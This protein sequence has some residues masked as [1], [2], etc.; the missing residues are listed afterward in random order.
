MMHDKINSDPAEDLRRA[1]QLADPRTSRFDP[2]PRIISLDDFDNGLCG[3]SQLV[4]NYEDSLDAMLPGY[5][6]H[7]AL[8][9]STMPHWEAGSH[10]GIDG[11][12]ALKL[13]TRPQAGSQNVAIK[14]MTFRHAG[15]IRFEAYFAF[16]PEATELQLGEVDV[17]SAGFL[18]DLQSGD[19]T[20]DGERVMPHFRF[21]NALDGERVQRWQYKSRSEPILPIGT[22]GKTISHYHLAPEGWEDLPDGDQRLCYNEIATKLNWHYLRFDFDLTTMQPIALQCNDRTYDVSTAQPMRFPAMSNLWCMLNICMFVETDTPK[23]ALLY[24][25]SACI[26]G[27]F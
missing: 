19:A 23:R 26:S 11:S 1:L 14:R 10:G 17:R 22:A 15:P 8:Q 3:W 4:G 24:L 13:A 2:L 16:K 20:P 21:L 6:Q 27:D 9:L 12:Y 7:N 5:A 18:F 25:D